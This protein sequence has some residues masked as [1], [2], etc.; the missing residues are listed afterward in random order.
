MTAIRTDPA[1]NRLYLR[2]EGELDADAVAD[3]AREVRAAIAS[4]QPGVDIVHDLRCVAPIDDEAL[5]TLRRALA[6]L[7]GGT[8]RRV[9]R[10]VDDGLPEIGALQLSIATA[11]EIFPVTVVSTLEQAEVFLDTQAS[12]R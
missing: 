12:A 5:R 8:I 1:A 7:P 11:D 9:V 3:A 4:L 10:V 2:F 6:L